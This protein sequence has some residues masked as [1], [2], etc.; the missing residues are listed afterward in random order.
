[1]NPEYWDFIKSKQKYNRPNK[2]QI[3]ALIFMKNKR[4]QI[5]EYKTTNNEFTAKSLI[6]KVHNPIIKKIVE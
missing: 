5:I 6:N 3:L 2:N 1:M 4:I